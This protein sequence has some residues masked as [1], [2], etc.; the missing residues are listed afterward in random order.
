MDRSR[1][2]VRYH[3]RHEFQQLTDRIE[4]RPYSRLI[5]ALIGPPLPIQEQRLN[6]LSSVRIANRFHRCPATK[7]GNLLTSPGL[8]LLLNLFL[9]FFSHLRIMKD[10]VYGLFILCPHLVLSRGF[11]KHLV[12]RPSDSPLV[13]RISTESLFDFVSKLLGALLGIH[14]S[15]QSTPRYVDTAENRVVPGRDFLVPLLEPI[16]VHGTESSGLVEFRFGQEVFLGSTDGQ[17]RQSFERR[18]WR[19][20]SEL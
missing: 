8:G 2:N 12:G 13:S 16:E 9:D 14:F 6:D 11:G 7:N 20:N 10:V 5:H 1:G 4:V 17:R 15:N 18:F 19:L 3:S